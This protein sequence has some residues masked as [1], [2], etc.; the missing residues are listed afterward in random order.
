MPTRHGNQQ[1]SVSP[2]RISAKNERSLQ[3]FEDQ[4]RVRYAERSAK[5]YVSMARAFIEWLGPIVL[6]DVRP[7]D[8]QAYQTHVYTLRKK[9]GTA[10][11]LGNQS[12]RLLAV[13]L[14]F[15]HLVKRG[16]VLSDPAARVEYPRR[17]QRLPRGI[18]SR[19][20]VRKLLAMPDAST[21]LGLRDRAVLEVFYAT[22]IRAG[23]L[24]KLKLSDI[25]TEDR[26]L[27]VLL[28]KGSKDRHVP[29]TRASVE[30]LEAYLVHGRPH[31]RKAAS[32]SWLF[33]AERGGK[34]YA[35]L[36]N[37]IVQR[38]AIA[39][40]IEKH[41]TCHTLRH[42]IATHLLKGG[43][44]IRHIQILLGHASLHATERYTHVEISDLTKALKR[45]HP[46]GR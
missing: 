13:K 9:D 42:S 19:E 46:R 33:L 7:Q 37:E 1:G 31:Y 3:A 22:G 27:R 28:G 32:S 26:V 44:D 5:G 12:N 38:S 41:V 40:R 10:L 24:A 36:L 25:D 39:A 20:E 2:R 4:A 21:P 34:P 29:L 15:R 14:F 43:A 6:S 8:V 16:D 35:S 30:A 18:L 45:A 17:E 23:E 11:S